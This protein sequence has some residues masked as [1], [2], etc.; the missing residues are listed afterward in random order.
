[1]KQELLTYSAPEYLTFVTGRLKKVYVAA[2]TNTNSS[3]TGYF[4]VIVAT[5]G[6]VPLAERHLDL[7]ECLHIDRS[8]RSP[9]HRAPLDRDQLSGDFIGGRV[10]PSLA[11]PVCDR[12]I[13]AWQSHASAVQYA[14][15]LVLRS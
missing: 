5:V 9:W 10:P 7:R 4:R 3:H 12:V 13:R 8:P 11:A 2:S 14:V 6:G 15:A 1:M